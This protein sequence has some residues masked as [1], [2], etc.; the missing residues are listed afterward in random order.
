MVQVEIVNRHKNRLFNKKEVEKIVA[1]G[2]GK[3]VPRGSVISVAFLGDREMTE[4]NE[5][6]TGRRGTTD[7]LSF[8]LGRDLHDK[9]WYGEIIISLDRAIKQAKEKGFGLKDE[10][11]RLLIHSLVHLGGFDHH[12]I[13]SFKKMRNL[14]FEL[15]LELL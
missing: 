4:I 9:R 8:P 11:K 10:I 5:A 2:A 6:Y 14:E 1:H 13:R 3:V 12:D 15:L 7:V